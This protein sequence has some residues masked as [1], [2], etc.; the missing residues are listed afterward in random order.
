MFYTP[1][2]RK[3]KGQPDAVAP[4]L[5]ESQRLAAVEAEV[6]AERSRLRVESQKRFDA[7]GL[8]HFIVPDE[9]MSAESA[10]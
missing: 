5:T 10:L 3:S 4:R 8:P 7:E 2:H 1:K 9:S 6:E